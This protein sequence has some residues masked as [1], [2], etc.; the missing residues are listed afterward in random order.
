[1]KPQVLEKQHLA[2]S[3]EAGSCNSGAWLHCS[4]A[5]LYSASELIHSL[6]TLKLKS[7]FFKKKKPGK[8]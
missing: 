8:V 7:V 1:M 4:V 2:A 6:C 3:P 5:P